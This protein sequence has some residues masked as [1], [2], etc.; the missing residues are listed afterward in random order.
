MHD[1]SH[2]G[3]WPHAN[4]QVCTPTTLGHTSWQKQGM[5]TLS[6]PRHASHRLP[7][8]SH[9]TPHLASM[10]AVMDMALAAGR[11]M[12]I[13]LSSTAS[14]PVDCRPMAA[15]VAMLVLLVRSMPE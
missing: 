6:V 4:P 13:M 1:A 12:L 14:T 10:P 3:R 2:P 5:P 9:C 7:H 8:P 15:L 11:T